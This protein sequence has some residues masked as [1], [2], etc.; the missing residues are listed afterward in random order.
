MIPQAIPVFVIALVVRC[1]AVN[2]LTVL[3]GNQSMSL[4]ERGSFALYEA[5][6]DWAADCAAQEELVPLP[7]S[8][9][10][11]RMVR[12]HPAPVAIEG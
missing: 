11:Y 6:A 7:F 1:Y 10:R 12:F 4:W 8:L 2:V 9:E 5:I 3:C